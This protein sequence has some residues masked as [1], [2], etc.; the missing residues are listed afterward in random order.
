MYT[1]YTEKRLYT[2]ELQKEKML[3]SRKNALWFE[4][5]IVWKIGKAILNLIIFQSFV[6]AKL[7]GILWDLYSN[8]HTC[9]L[10]FHKLCNDENF[11]NVIILSSMQTILD[12]VEMFCATTLPPNIILQQVCKQV[13]VENSFT[14]GN[15]KNLLK[16]VHH[17]K[18]VRG[19]SNYRYKYSK[20]LKN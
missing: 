20:V 15:S 16:R 9:N 2:A 3:S 5:V 10:I 14:G 12:V 7:L 17:N 11:T 1:G 18:F 4:A 13:W 6:V 19:R 8:S